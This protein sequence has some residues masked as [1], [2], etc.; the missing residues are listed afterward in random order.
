MA[1]DIGSFWNKKIEVPF[2]AGLKDR[3]SPTKRSLTLSPKSER[4]MAGPLGDSERPF[5]FFTTT[6]S[7]PA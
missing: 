4:L 3:L 7:V 1:V 6:L 2:V 5:Q